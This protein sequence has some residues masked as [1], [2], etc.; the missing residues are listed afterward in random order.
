MKIQ[1]INPAN[2]KI[3]KEF[4]NFTKAKVDSAVENARDTQITWQKTT[5]EERAELFK[6]LKKVMHKR[7]AEILELIKEET[8]KMTPDCEAEL[9][10]VIDAVDYYL[11]EFSKVK[12]QNYTFNPETF[13]KT[14][15]EIQYVPQG[16]I[17][18]ILPWNFPFYP[19]MVYIIPALVSGSAVVFKPSE[20]ST[21]V[22]LLCKELFVEAS[23][24]KDLIQI[25]IGDEKVGKL[26]VKSS[27]NKLF[28]IGSVEAG[29]DI[30]QNFG[31]RPV[32]LELGGNSAALVLEDADLNLAAKSIAWG[33]TYNA[34]QEC[35]S[36]KRVY[37]V[38]KVADKFLVKITKIVKNLRAGIDYGPYI[39]ME[40]LEKVYRRIQDSRKNGAK[41]LCGGDKLDR[42]NGYW[43]SPSVILAKNDDIE[44]IK[45]ET[46][47]N[48]V[49]VVIVKNED[50]AI[51][52]ANDTNYGLS[53]SVFSM[54]IKNAEEI[55]VKLESGLV[56]IN[57]TFITFPGWDHWTGWKDSGIET[58]ESKIQQCLKKKVV[59]KNESGKKRSFWYP[60]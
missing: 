41:V 49:P 16:V 18:L 54:N 44:L 22:G 40:A 47:G 57:E 24:P 55:A 60:Y 31:I 35:V 52:K 28:M 11:G 1:S 53:N 27:I 58:T 59:S 26:L 9:Y 23:F 50:E 15:A 13:P 7:S 33:G 32:Q 29:K 30:L 14:T 20:Y 46:F 42:N 8:G 25:L 21:L 4:E 12:I 19:P 5:F 37:V 39:R 36:V 51:S 34:G 3:L 38:K 56:S 48:T 17:G 2:G 45:K 43:L 10:D 6:R